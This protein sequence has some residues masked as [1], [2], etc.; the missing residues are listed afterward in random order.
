MKRNESFHYFGSH[1][2]V[3]CIGLRPKRIIRKQVSKQLAPT[4][5]LTYISNRRDTYALLGQ[6]FK[7]AK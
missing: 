3:E 1:N 5:E 7:A 6:C 4:D 2:F